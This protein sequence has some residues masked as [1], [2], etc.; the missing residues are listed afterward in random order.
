MSGEKK[1]NI[2]SEIRSF[3]KRYGEE[4]NVSVKWGLPLVGFADATHPSILALKEVV[5]P[6]HAMP[7]DVL[8]DAA[9]IIACYIPFTRE[10][11]KANNAAGRLASPEWAQAY[12]QTNAMFVRLHAHMIQYLEKLGYQAAVSKEA[13]TFDQD[14]LISN[15]SQRHI[16]YAA[17]LGTFGLNNMLITKSGCCGRFTTLVT[18]LDVEPDAP[19]DEELCRYK[20]SGS[21]C[22]CVKRCPTGALSVSGYDRQKCYSLLRE[23]AKIYTG[24]G[25]SYVKAGSE[26]ANGEGSEV[27]GKCIT[28][29]PC[30]FWKTE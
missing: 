1:G 29:S 16:A 4:A 18:N 14:A 28:S 17:G 15:W 2:V 9:V 25:S 27:C 12:E 11:A 19:M 7:S 30:A 10:L 24:F 22:I 8:A 5:S 3:V 6:F 13:Q 26:E 21:C 23:N 20:T